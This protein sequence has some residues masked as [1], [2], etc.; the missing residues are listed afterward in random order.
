V[1]KLARSQGLEVMTPK[2][3]KNNEDFLAKLKDSN[4]DFF[5]VA[6]YGKILP[7][8]VLNVPRL[9][10]INLH[11]S[12]LPKHRGASPIQAA[13]AAGDAETGV[14]LMAMDAEMDHGDVYDIERVTIDPKDTH[15]TLEKKLSAIAAE[16]LVRDLPR[17]A[18]DEIKPKRQD[19][20]LAT[21]TR[22]IRK[23]DG[24]VDWRTDAG[25]TVINKLRAYTPWPGLYT[26]WQ[27]SP[28]KLIRLNIK[29]IRPTAAPTPAPAPGRVFRSPSGYPSVMTADGGVEL[30]TLQPEGKKPLDGRVFLNGYQDF[31]GTVLN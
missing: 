28:N 1:A 9:G 29:E 7:D 11:G 24:L 8:S 26:I 23:E 14:S 15:A 12:I 19:H 22:I 6:A 27:R 30:V 21:F 25:P 31:M 18:R 17:I 2:K 10:S 4:A 13:L 5:V 3:I 20:D 16:Q